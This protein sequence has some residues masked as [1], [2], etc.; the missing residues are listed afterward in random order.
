MGKQKP[1]LVKIDDDIWQHAR[2]RAP[3]LGQTLSAFVEQAI[4]NHLELTGRTAQTML[5]RQAEITANYV[6]SSETFNST[7]STSLPTA[8]SAS[9]ASHTSTKR[10]R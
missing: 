8:Q 5:T 3:V 2:M 9:L 7:S 6:S 1:V 4:V 10:R